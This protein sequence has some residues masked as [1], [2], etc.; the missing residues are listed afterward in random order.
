M[1]KN[2]NRH[3]YKILQGHFYELF[4]EL[5]YEHLCKHLW[6]SGVRATDF[7]T[8]PTEGDVF[9]KTSVNELVKGVR[10]FVE[11]QNASYVYYIYIYIY[12]SDINVRGRYWQGP[13]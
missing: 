6:R 12:V 4:Y 5:F 9:V 13:I 2:I 7:V 11:N 10:E 1:Y 3:R 8:Q